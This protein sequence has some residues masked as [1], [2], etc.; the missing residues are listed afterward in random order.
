MSVYQEV[1]H[2]VR[3]LAASAKITNT[4]LFS[5]DITRDETDKTF[6]H[7]S[8]EIKKMRG[9][10]TLDFYLSGSEITNLALQNMSIGFKSLRS[11]QY[12]KIRLVECGY[13]DD[14]SIVYVARSLK[15][16]ISLQTLNVSFDEGRE[17]TDKGIKPLIKNLK[18]LKNL[19]TLNISFH[20]DGG[21]CFD[22]IGD[23]AKAVQ[24][25]KFLKNI[26]FNFSLAEQMGPEGIKNISK[27]LEVLPGLENI[28]LRL[29]EC[30]IEDQELEVLI[31][32]FQGKEHL[33]MIRLDLSRNDI[34]DKSLVMISE[35]FKELKV[36]E[37]IKLQLKNCK[38]ITEEGTELLRKNLQGITSLK[39]FGNTWLGR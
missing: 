8:E 19:Q 1:N 16:L 7:Y 34:T 39:K 15:K 22:E 30:N 2:I 36:I 14:P 37:V 35:C 38:K 33:K 20:Y 11:L 24:G 13:I 3:I 31:E 18:Y 27:M 6:L 17:I 25:L 29:L 21:I 32:G 23:V 4:V 12:L 10:K 28:S 5:Y 26:K 9:L